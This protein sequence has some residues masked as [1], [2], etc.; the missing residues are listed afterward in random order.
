MR[1]LLGGETAGG[2]ILF[3]PW[4]ECAIYFYIPVSSLYFHFY[5]HLQ[6]KVTPCCEVTFDATDLPHSWNEV[7]CPQ[8]FRGIPEV[9]LVSTVWP[10]DLPKVR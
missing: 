3:I 6:K 5:F 7:L 10:P 4:F 2:N 8:V 9:D 1:G